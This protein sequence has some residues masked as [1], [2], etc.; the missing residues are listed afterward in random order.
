[1]ASPNIEIANNYY[2]DSQ[3]CLHRYQLTYD[4][5]FE[6]KSQR[7]KIF[8]DLRMAAECVMKAYAVYF[9]PAETTREEVIDKARKYSHNINK[10]SGSIKEH[11]T[12]ELWAKLEP[13]IQQLGKLPVGL[14]YRLDGSDFR[15]I[16]EDLYYKTVGSDDWLKSLHE[17]LTAVAE[18]LNVKLQSHSTI[19]SSAETLP[20]L[21]D[22]Q[23]KLNKNKKS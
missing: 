13:F 4:S 18:S 23:K 2:H 14:R 20:R 8:I 12:E 10:L 1:M 17:T 19:T 16:N 3:D 11:L 15:E 6:I 9:L 5:L 21:I 7:F 22:Y